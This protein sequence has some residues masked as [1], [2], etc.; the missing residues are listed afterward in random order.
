MYKR[1]EEKKHSLQENCTEKRFSE[2]IRLVHVRDN[3]PFVT[4]FAVTKFD[5]IMK[6][7][8]FHFCLNRIARGTLKCKFS[9]H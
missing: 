2:N 9:P 6:T 1:R 8:F 7:Q 3:R 4:P 5:N